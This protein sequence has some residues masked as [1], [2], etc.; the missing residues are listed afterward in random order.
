M[1]MR[2]P[3]AFQARGETGTTWSSVMRFCLSAS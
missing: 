1:N 3:C 2:E